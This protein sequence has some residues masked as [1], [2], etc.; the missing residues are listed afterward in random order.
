MTN[1]K[2]KI[3]LQGH[4]KF[5]LREGWLSKGMIIVQENPGVFSQKN[6]SDIFGLGSNMVKSIRYWMK[7]FGLT[8]SNGSNLSEFGELIAKYD[9]YLEDTFTLWLLHSNIVKNKEEATTWYMYFNYCDANGLDKEQIE[10]ILFREITKYTMGKAFSEKSLK[11]D[12]SVL[13][14]MYSPNKEKLDPEDKSVCPFSR[15]ELMKSYDGKYMRNYPDRRKFNELLVLY[16]ISYRLGQRE[17]ISIDEVVE[18]ENGLH[19]IYNLTSVRSNELFDKLDASGYLRV[20]RT[21]GLDML[22]P[23]KKLEAKQI[24]E[25]YYEN[26]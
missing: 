19:K 11:N 22:Y 8:N 12:I 14:N 18:G 5:S 6:A 16:E 24:L 23:T 15:L 13:L 20:D 4:E 21:A 2:V 10:K 3:R 17:G 25:M 7:A 26:Y 1:S 9:L